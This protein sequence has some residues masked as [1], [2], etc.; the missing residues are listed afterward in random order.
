[1]FDISDLFKRKDYVHLDKGEA[2]CAI[3]EFANMIHEI[4]QR[5]KEEKSR[6]GLD[7]IYMMAFLELG[8]KN[9]RPDDA[10]SADLKQKHL[11]N[12]YKEMLK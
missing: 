6:M 8:K 4:R 12:M 5:E 3:Y 11:L 1:M 10:A 9:L 2:A 7:C